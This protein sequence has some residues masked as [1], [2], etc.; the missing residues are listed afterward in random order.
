MIVVVAIGE[1]GLSRGH[2]E[3]IGAAGQLAGLLGQQTSLVAVG[4]GAAAAAARAGRY[5]MNRAIAVDMA[6]SDFG[7]EGYLENVTQI[8]A[9]LDPTIVL[10]SGDAISREAG[11]RL[12]ARLGGAA[13]HDVIDLRVDHGQIIWTR[14]VFGGKALADMALKRAPAVAVLQPGSFAAPDPVGELADVDILTGVAPSTRVRVIERTAPEQSGP[15]R[16]EAA[17]GVGGGEGLGGQAGVRQLEVMAAVLGG[18]VGATLAAVDRGWAPGDRQIGQTGKVVSP[19]LYFAVGISGASQHVAGIAGAKTVVAVNK[20]AS[21]PIF[22]IA[23]LGVVMDYQ[24]F[25]PALI[26]AL[27]KAKHED[28]EGA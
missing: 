14:P 17:V 26:E 18:A 7:A 9:G 11:P 27:R 1:A 16:E 2:L 8:L 5:G 19:D 13:V 23:R 3:A 15:R 6:L 22:K 21:A 28:C 20:D 25:L 10:L 24:N 12:A 4:E